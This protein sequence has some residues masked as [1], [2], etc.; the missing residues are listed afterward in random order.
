M[1][2][3]TKVAIVTGA[4]TGVGRAVALALEAA[5]DEVA[6]IV[7]ELR[8]RAILP[9]PDHRDTDLGELKRRAAEASARPR[10]KEGEER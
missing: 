7:D 9:A 1:G 6:A 4:G 2:A 3:A 5:A 10:A 8:A